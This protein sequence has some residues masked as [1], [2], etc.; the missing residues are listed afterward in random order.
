[1]TDTLAIATAGAPLTD[2]KAVAVLLH[3]RGASAESMLSLAKVFAQ[4]DIAYMAPQAAGGSWYPY[5]FLAPIAQNEPSLSHSLAAI[6]SLVDDLASRGISADR[7]ALIGFSQGGCLALEFAARNA[8]RYGAL[9]GLSAGLIGP[10]N[11]PRDYSGS[12]AGTPVFL[13]CSDVDA[14]IPLA[15]VHETSRVLGA[16][17]GVITERIY[18]GLS[19]TINDDEIGHARAVLAG[20]LHNVQSS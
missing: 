8:Q 17:G 9:I 12:L 6:G 1:M 5:S 13:G 15:R 7:I 20:L 16:L 18:P 3:G 11:N 2:A 14:H 10:G 19:H 4:P